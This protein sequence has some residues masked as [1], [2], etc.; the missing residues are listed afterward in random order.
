MNI[1]PPPLPDPRVKDE[2]HLR[3][4]SVFHWVMAGL[5]LLGIGFMGLHYS[6]MRMVLGSTEIWKNSKDGPP[7]EFIW[8]LMQW[9][10][11]GFGVIILVLGVLNVMVGFYLRRKKRHIFCLVVAGFNCLNF[12]FGTALGVFTFIVL[13]RDSVLAAFKPRQEGAAAES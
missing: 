5:S 2:E 1:T 7:P 4:L 12:P 13:L 10:Y 9:F 11:L 3:L 8:D 6:I